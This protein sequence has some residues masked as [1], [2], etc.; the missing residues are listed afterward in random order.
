MSV[1]V[2]YG[3]IAVGAK[4]TFDIQDIEWN[5]YWEARCDKSQLK[6]N[7]T[8]PKNYANPCELYQTL[9]DGTMSILPDDLSEKDVGIWSSTVS[10]ENGNFGTPVQLV[11]KST[12]GTFSFSGL[13]FIYDTYNNIY[14]TYSQVTTYNV[15]GSTSTT[16]ANVILRLKTSDMAFFSSLGSEGCNQINVVFSY[17]NMPYNR[18]KVFGIEYG[19]GSL[20]E[21]D[22]ITSAAMT[23]EVNLTSESLASTQC[24]ISFHLKSIGLRDFTERQPMTVYFN[25][26]EIFKGYIDTAKRTGE[27]DWRVTVV[28]SIYYLDNFLTDGMDALNASDVFDMIEDKGINITASDSILNITTGNPVEAGTYRDLLQQACFVANGVG[29]SCV[30]ATAKDEIE[31]KELNE[32]VAHVID[33]SR[34]RQE[35][36]VDSETTITEVRIEYMGSKWY[37]KTDLSKWSLSTRESFYNTSQDGGFLSV[38]HN[39][40]GVGT[41]SFTYEN[42]IVMWA[43]CLDTN[44]E[45]WWQNESNTL[46][47]STPVWEYASGTSSGKTLTITFGTF[48][49]QGTNISKAKLRVLTTA[50]TSNDTELYVS[51]SPE[52]LPYGVVERGITITDQS[53]VDPLT[54]QGIL[55]NVYDMYQKKHTGTISIEEKSRLPAYDKAVYGTAQYG[56]GI[57]D[58]P[59]ELGDT[60]KVDGGYLGEVTGIIKSMSYNLN[61][62]ILVKECEVVW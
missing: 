17:I 58:T 19:F 59:I 55:D 39:K 6:K 54:A 37:E 20:I 3:N 9:L 42:P 31:V 45:Q 50:D 48:S 56:I 27:L 13:T 61:G 18:L 52:T 33:K 44:H 62:N 25:S 1:S 30:I 46:N 15:T 24:E 57:D 34:I 29:D 51:K 47:V 8:V 22:E 7:Y 53:A 60:I 10:D 12:S 23:E 36:A 2:Y 32:N 11:L 49:N 28:D 26:R 40:Y 41:F 21:S 43:F 5:Q 38:L 16:L 4:E 14:A 35:L